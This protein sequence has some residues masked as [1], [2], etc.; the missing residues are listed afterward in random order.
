VALRAAARAL[1]STGGFRVDDEKACARAPAHPHAGSMGAVLSQ[2]YEK[3]LALFQE[4]EL[5]LAVA[6]M[7]FCNGHSHVHAAA[8]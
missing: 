1:F 3:L 6:P 8:A 4:K 2:L 7:F 5:E